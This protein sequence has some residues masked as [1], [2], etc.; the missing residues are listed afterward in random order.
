MA[1]R[2]S[3]FYV[4][5]WFF[6]NIA[7]PASFVPAFRLIANKLE[8]DGDDKRLHSFLEYKISVEIENKFNTVE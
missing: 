1:I 5:V 4:I 6:L 2:W 7:Q 3:K 8:Y